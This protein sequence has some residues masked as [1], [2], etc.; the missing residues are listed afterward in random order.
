MHMH[1]R[2]W[3]GGRDERE[4]E[5]ENFLVLSPLIIKQEEIARSEIL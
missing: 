2:T 4:R 5:S 3:L 1:A